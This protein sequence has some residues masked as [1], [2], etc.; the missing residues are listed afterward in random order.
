MSLLAKST[1]RPWGEAVCLHGGTTGAIPGLNL[2]PT[3]QLSLGRFPGLFW[4]LVTLGSWHEV[5]HFIPV[6]EGGL[7]PAKLPGHD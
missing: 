1:A 4:E 2:A 6:V 7:T 5:T 3:S